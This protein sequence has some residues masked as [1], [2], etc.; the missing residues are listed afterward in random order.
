MVLGATKTNLGT[1]NH[2][3]RLEDKQRWIGGNCSGCSLEKI[4]KHDRRLSAVTIVGKVREHGWE[5][6]IYIYTYSSIFSIAN[7]FFFKT[8]SAS[9]PPRRG[10]EQNPCPSYPFPPPPTTNYY[11]SITKFHQLPSLLTRTNSIPPTHP[12]GGGWATWD[13][14]TFKT[15]ISIFV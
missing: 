1:F 8:R 13:A 14:A 5:T 4:K 15:S 6:C 12:Q 10:Q 7:Y 11:H 2:E 9:L 3:C